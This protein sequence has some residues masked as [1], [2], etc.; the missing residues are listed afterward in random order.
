MAVNLNDGQAYCCRALDAEY[1]KPGLQWLYRGR[2]LTTGSR[3]GVQQLD[4]VRLVFDA[5][6]RLVHKVS[7]V[8]NDLWNTQ[9]AKSVHKIKVSKV[10]N[11]LWNTQVHHSSLLP[12]IANAIQTLKTVSVHD[13]RERKSAARDMWKYS[14]AVVLWCVWGIYSGQ[15]CVVSCVLVAGAKPHTIWGL[16]DCISMSMFADICAITTKI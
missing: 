14:P 2:K 16:T 6:V 1:I 5:A 8:I 11:N 3:L 4:S 10:I 13:P 12:R 7:K 9:Q 15:K